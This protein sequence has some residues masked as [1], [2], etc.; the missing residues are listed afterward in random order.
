[1][2]N[3][4]G[5]IILKYKKNTQLFLKIVSSLKLMEL[6]DKGTILLN[7]FSEN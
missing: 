4:Y 6:A 3:T 5:K 7:S 1:M 2:K